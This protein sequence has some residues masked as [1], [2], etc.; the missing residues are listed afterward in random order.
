MIFIFPPQCAQ[1][2]RK[3]SR[4]AQPGLDRYIERYN[5]VLIFFI[6]VEDSKVNE[7]VSTITEASH[8]GNLGDGKIF[9][10]TIDD[11]LISQL[12]KKEKNTSK[13]VLSS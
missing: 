6:V 10:S 13:L 5:D 2:S 7:V 11:V 3:G 8:T 1:R 12:N 4:D 9:I